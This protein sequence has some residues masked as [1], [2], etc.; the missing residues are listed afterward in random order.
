LSNSLHT[1]EVEFI[2]STGHLIET[3]NAVTIHVDNNQCAASLTTPTLNGQTADPICG[4]LRYTGANALPV[5]M[6]LVGTHPNGFATYSF[7]VVKGVNQ[8]IGVGGPVPAISPVTN[9]ASTM[10]GSCTIAG[11]GEYL[12]VAAS[13]NNGWSRQSQYDASSA[14]AFVLAP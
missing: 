4:L 10:L 14:L 8:V 9:P 1:I 13:A 5:T 3:S 11:F 12:Y 2:G 7:Q 6:P